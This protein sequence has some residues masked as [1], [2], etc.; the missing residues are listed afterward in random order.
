MELYYVLLR[1]NVLGNYIPLKFCSGE[2]TSF[3]TRDGDSYVLNGHKF[4]IT[5]GPDA[6]VLVVYAKTDKRFITIPLLFVFETYTVSGMGTNL[7]AI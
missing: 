6:D 5:N 4:W 3:F 2:A 7:I 1:S